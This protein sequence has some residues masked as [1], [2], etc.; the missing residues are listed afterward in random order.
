MRQVEVFHAVADAKRAALIINSLDSLSAH[1]GQSVSVK[2][3]FWSE[4]CLQDQTLLQQLQH[5]NQNPNSIHIRLDQTLFPNIDFSSKPIDLSHFMGDTD[6]EEFQTLVQAI[7]ERTK[8]NIKPWKRL[9]KKAWA[10]IGVFTA[11]M[12][13]LGSVQAF[14]K[15]A[16]KIPGVHGVCSH[17]GIAGIPTPQELAGF[18]SAK[19][20]GCDGI[21]DFLS[22]TEN[23]QLKTK[24]QVLL[25]TRK[26]NITETPNTK[27]ITQPTL[28]FSRIFEQAIDEVSALKLIEEKVH[29]K[30]RDDCKGYSAAGYKYL[31]HRISALNNKPAYTCEET[32]VGWRC[33]A[34]AE[35]TCEHSFV[36]FNEVEVC[37]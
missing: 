37:S 2:L 8:A 21:R 16:C 23:E 5:A 13:L 34:E 22:A 28:F 29:T 1:Q 24:A 32:T 15:L 17:F 19:S 26:I 4:H 14:Q 10:S 12:G 31:D 33:K 3:C 25:D 9:S 35:I 11:V 18:Q 36:E 27:A 20:K 30:A 6:S 7:K